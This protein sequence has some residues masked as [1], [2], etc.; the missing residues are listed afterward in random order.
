MTRFELIKVWQDYLSG[1]GLPSFPLWGITN[2]T[3]RC[4]EGAKCS[5]PGK[6]PKVA[7]WRSLSG[8]HEV[9]PLDNLGVSTDHLVVIDIDSGDIPDDLPETFTVSTGRGWHLWYWANPDYPI[10][11]RAG[12]R[13]KIDIRAIGGLVAAPP[14][15]HYLGHDYVY[16]SGTIQ[17]VPEAILRDHERHIERQRQA[18]VT[19]VKDTTDESILPLVENLIAE[20]E[21]AVEGER[22]STLF[23]IACRMMD[24]ARTGWVGGDS[25]VSLIAAAERAGLT[26]QEAA[27]TIHSASQA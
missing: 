26:R 13:P 10:R 5:Q 16:T 27:R 25:F 24:L 20:M 15:R 23:R 14:S 19:Q 22:N 3:C 4:R 6:H 7:G 17:P 2:G 21:A 8:P 18:A 12:W 9:G 11:N 1:L